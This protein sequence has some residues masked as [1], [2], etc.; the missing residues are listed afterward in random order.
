MG[1][2]AGMRRQNCMQNCFGKELAVGKKLK[3]RRINN[4]KGES[5]LDS[6]S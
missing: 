6:C 1:N 2:I 5:R 4:R 3:L